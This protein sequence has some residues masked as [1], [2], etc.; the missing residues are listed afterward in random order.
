MIVKKV[1]LRSSA[2]DEVLGFLKEH[3]K[4]QLIRAEFIHGQK[5]AIHCVQQLLKAFAQKRNIS[6]KEEI[7]L[8]LIALAE[9]QIKKAIEKN[10]L[11]GEVVF[12]SW[13]DEA[14]S[15]YEEFRNRFVARELKLEEEDSET[16]QAI[17]KSATFWIH[18]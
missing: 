10:S 6:S 9:R 16:L 4:T 14:E 18:S 8:I 5:H 12:I 13:A 15:F 1:L 2:E 7:E 17:E 3:P 11:E